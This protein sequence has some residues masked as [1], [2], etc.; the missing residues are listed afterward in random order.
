MLVPPQ[1]L[2]AEGHSRTYSH[3]F[4][5]SPFCLLVKL[6]IHTFLWM[7][8][9]K[10]TQT[11]LKVKIGFFISFCVRTLFTMYLFA[12]G[13]F[14]RSTKVTCLE[15]SNIKELYCI[16]LFIFFF[17]FSSSFNIDDNKEFQLLFLDTQ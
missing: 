13:M 12:N 6:C 1:T 11:L 5:D 9:R 7:L 4:C 8:S 17:F 15:G 14:L 10:Q 16:L 2:S 3:F